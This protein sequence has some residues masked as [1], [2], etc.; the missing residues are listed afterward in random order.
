MRAT[1]ATEE[2]E[3]VGESFWVGGFWFVVRGDSVEV[4]IWICA[5]AC[6]QGV[7]GSVGEDVQRV[8]SR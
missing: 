3:G 5:L 7:G 2:E 1:A 8:C 6:E 4:G